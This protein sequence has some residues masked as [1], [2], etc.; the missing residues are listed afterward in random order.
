MLET[1]KN[2]F[3]GLQTCWKASKIIFGGFLLIFFNY[4]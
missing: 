1:F 4:K 3:W 2:D